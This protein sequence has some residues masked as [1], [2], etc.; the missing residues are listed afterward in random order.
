MSAIDAP[1]SHPIVF[2]ILAVISVI[3]AGIA[4]RLTSD[5][6]FH[7]NAPSSTIN[8]SVRFIVF[9]GWWSALLSIAYTVL[10]LT[11]AGKVFISI[12]GHG[13]WLLSTWLFFL[14][15][16]GALTVAVGS[17]ENCS[18]SALTH[19]NDL[20]ALIAFTWIGW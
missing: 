18:T 5:F 12:A 9:I 14:A 19:K 15:G 3:V 13:V 8:G 10:F 2:S 6:N 7:Q 20:L 4:S 16:A 1:F 11:G 17:A